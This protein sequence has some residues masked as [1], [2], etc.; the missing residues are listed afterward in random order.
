MSSSLHTAKVYRI[1]HTSCG[2][3]M[4]GCDGQE[5][6]YNIFSMFDIETSAEGRFDDEYEVRR[7]ELERLRT[8]LTERNE[9]YQAHADEFREELEHAGRSTSD[10]MDVLDHLIEASDQ[11]NEWVLI[12]WF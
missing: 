7:S 1:E 10:F 9:E 3:G 2:Q 6:L 4:F 11:S 5:A 12:S 8:I